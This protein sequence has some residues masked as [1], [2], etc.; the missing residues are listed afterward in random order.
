MTTLF[1]EKSFQM[2]SCEANLIVQLDEHE[3]YC[4]DEGIGMNCKFP[5]LLC[6]KEDFT[7]F[8][9]A[10]PP[11][12]SKSTPTKVKFTLLNPSIPL[13]PS[14]EDPPHDIPS[15]LTPLHT[16]LHGETMKPSP[17]RTFMGETLELMSL[18]ILHLRKGLLT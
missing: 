18:F 17:L 6:T 2:S 14:H 12:P 15:N 1:S 11:K 9:K 3:N 16:M 4:F 7:R 10:I 5:L 13:N 8:K